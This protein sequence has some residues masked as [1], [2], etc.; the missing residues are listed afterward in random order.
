MNKII[1]STI[2]AAATIL[3]TSICFFAYD[4]TIVY[5][6]T[7][8]IGWKRWWKPVREERNQLGFRG[9]YSQ[10]SE[11]LGKKVVLLVGDS[12]VETSHPLELT[13]AKMLE[14]YLG[15]EYKVISL[16][17]WGYGNI[18][19]KISIEEALKYANK[20]NL[21]V[22]DIVLWFTS[23]D[24]TDNL[25]RTG[26][27]GLRSYYSID[28][29]RILNPSPILKLQIKITNA[30]SRVKNII[31]RLLSFETANN[32]SDTYIS[33]SDY[34]IK[35]HL[36]KVLEGSPHH[37]NSTLNLLKKDI[38]PDLFKRDPMRDYSKK[39]LSLD[40]E[41][42]KKYSANALDDLT[43][44]YLLSLN[45]YRDF[46]RSQSFSRRSIPFSACRVINIP[47]FSSSVYP[48]ISNQVLNDIKDVADS[49]GI[50][51]VILL[52]EKHCFTFKNDFD[53]D[54]STVYKSSEGIK[55]FESTFKGLNVITPRI[56]WDYDSFDGFDGHLS[57]KVNQEVMRF[58][59][60]WIKNR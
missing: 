31:Y 60:D 47:G 26:F 19:H 37:L 41:N 3:L 24:Y 57:N 28:D 43:T 21:R 5:G 13:P 35:N 36:K 16:G 30:F 27:N 17:S 50:N 4:R 29:G 11:Y 23:N 45:D 9:I 56:E 51:M 10:P 44:D 22:S 15:S 58:T 54:G 52:T 8:D 25:N 48:R 7:Y 34:A 33:P 49:S 42:R 2:P 55:S 32:R 39:W 12:Q 1:K 20:N 18:Q 40:E 38:D 59:S 6:N 14:S 53:L 46:S